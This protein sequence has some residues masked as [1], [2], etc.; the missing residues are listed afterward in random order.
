MAASFA[1]AA[2]SAVT[3]RTVV[4]CLLTHQEC[5]QKLTTEIRGKNERSDPNY[6]KMPYL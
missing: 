1:A 2:E 6:L 4:Y 3:L 5:Y